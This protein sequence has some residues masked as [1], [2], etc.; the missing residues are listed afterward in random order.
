MTPAAIEHLRCRLFLFAVL[1]AM[2]DL[3]KASEEARSILGDDSFSIAFKTRSGLR[4]AYFMEG[5]TCRF[6]WGKAVEKADVE[7]FFHSDSQANATFEGRKAI[8]PMPTRG[9]GKINRVKIFQDIAA[10]LEDFLQ[11]SGEALRDGEYRNVFVKTYLG[12]ILRSLCQLCEHERV[13]REIFRTGPH[14][15]AQFQLGH[16]GV[17]TWLNLAPRRLDWGRGQPPRPSDVCVCF[18]DPRVALKALHDDM[19]AQAELGLGTMEISGYAPLA[20]HINLLMERIELYLPRGETPV[21][22]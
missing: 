1:P 7:L 6:D 4:G 12:I 11:P 2:D 8:P 10:I 13:S 18:N 17:P 22:F 21:G 9:F 16:D 20:E 15:I 19:D 5:S 3:L 14:G